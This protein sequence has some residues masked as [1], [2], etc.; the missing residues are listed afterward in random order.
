M[1]EVLVSCLNKNIEWHNRMNIQTNSIII[2]QT[3]KKIERS[4]LEKK[5]NNNNCRF[6]SFNEFGVGLSRNNALMR[7]KENICVMADEDEVF[8]NGYEKIIRD[9]YAKYP[10]ADMIVFDVRIHKGEKTTNRVKKNGRVRFYNALKYGTVTFTFKRNS[11]LKKNIF[12]SLLFGGGSQFMSGED[13]LFISDCLKNGLKV[14]SCKDVIADV[15]NEDSTWFNGYNEKY[16]IDRGALFA[17]LSSNFSLVYIL[18]FAIRKRN[19]FN[20]FTLIEI[21]EMMLRGSKKINNKN[22]NWYKM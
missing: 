19:L 9:A 2:N 8:V 22:S 12:F 7:A 15:Y 20:N 14:Y 16:L 6:Y 4:F 11:V 21:I 5:F 13:S 18:Q 17:V 1:L 3:E 10:D